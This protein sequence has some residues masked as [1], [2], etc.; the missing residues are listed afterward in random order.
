MFNDLHFISPPPPK[1][2]KKG[3]K[4]G[5]G[6]WAPVKGRIHIRITHGGNIGLHL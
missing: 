1:K 5:S 6:K 2:N 4:G 3:G